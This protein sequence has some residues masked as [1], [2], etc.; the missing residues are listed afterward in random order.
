MEVC[1]WGEKLHKAHK[2][3]LKHQFQIKPKGKKTK[4]QYRKWNYNSYRNSVDPIII[5]FTSA[6]KFA[7][8]LVFLKTVVVFVPML[9]D[10]VV[11]VV[12][13]EIVQLQDFSEVTT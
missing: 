6:M 12:F 2:N 4:G 10:L 1:N 5:V 9:V 13:A 3:N 8:T 11:V 7:V